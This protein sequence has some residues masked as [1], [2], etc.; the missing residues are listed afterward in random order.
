MFSDRSFNRF[1]RI[2]SREIERINDHLP[3]E[4]KT[5]RELLSMDEPKVITRRGD[6]LV[7]DK[8][9]LRLLAELTPPHYHDKLRLPILILRRIDMGE[10][11]YV[12]CGGELEAHVISRVL[13]ESSLPRDKGKILLYRPHIAFLRSKL[14]TTTVIGFVADIT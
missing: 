11:V 7:M 9:E 6:E 12:L 14:R 3:R 10:G 4:S 13:S 2:L 1:T 5:L 8:D